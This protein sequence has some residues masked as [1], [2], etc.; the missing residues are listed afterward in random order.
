MLNPQLLPPRALAD[1][2]AKVSGPLPDPW[3]ELSEALAKALALEPH[4]DLSLP[5]TRCML[6]REEKTAANARGFLGDGVKDVVRLPLE[7]LQNHLERLR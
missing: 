1:A 3:K 4:P 7:S 2:L 5:K 6:C